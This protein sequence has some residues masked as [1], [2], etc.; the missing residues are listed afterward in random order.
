MRRS[1]DIQTEQ[2]GETQFSVALAFIQ[3]KQLF[4]VFLLISWQKNFRMHSGFRL[5]VRELVAVPERPIQVR[6]G[7]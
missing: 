5:H 6:Y 2:Q 7:M 4:T 1:R 3:I